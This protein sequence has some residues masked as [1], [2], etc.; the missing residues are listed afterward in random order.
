MIV[1][2]IYRKHKSK[3]IVHFDISYYINDKKNKN[4]KKLYVN[5]AQKGV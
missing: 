4:K 1:I 2:T 3:S 5:K